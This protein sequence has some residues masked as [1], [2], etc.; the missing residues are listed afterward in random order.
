MEVKDV[1]KGTQYENIKTY[2]YVYVQCQKNYHLYQCILTND[3]FVVIFSDES[4][5]SPFVF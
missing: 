3:P 4:C 2:V 1:F 5:V